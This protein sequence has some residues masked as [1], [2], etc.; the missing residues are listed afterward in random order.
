MRGSPLPPRPEAGTLLLVISTGGPTNPFLSSRPE[1][2]QI[3]SCH[4]DRRLPYLFLSSRPEVRAAGRSGEI[5]PRTNR[6]GRLRRGPSAAPRNP[7][8]RKADPEMELR[9]IRGQMSR[10][11]S[12]PLD[13]TRG[14]N[15]Q[16]RHDKP[17]R[18]TLE[19]TN[20]GVRRPYGP[21]L[22]GE[23]LKQNRHHPGGSLPTAPLR[24]GARRPWA[25]PTPPDRENHA[26]SLSAILQSCSEKSKA[27]IHR[28]RR[29]RL[30]KRPIAN[31][32]RCC[33]LLS[34]PSLS[35]RARPS[36]V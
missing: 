5:W 12:A 17:W 34:F 16:A 10:L 6:V 27:G 14:E 23:R 33:G 28:V 18:A 15:T 36:S 24:V 4:L 21:R 22:N 7:F 31:P 30:A 20:L 13:M 11:R 8:G 26:G 9:Q 2:R 35:D 1:A 19:M 29:P 32:P 25:W 3:P